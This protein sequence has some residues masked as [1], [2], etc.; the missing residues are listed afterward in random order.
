MKGKFAHIISVISAL[1]LILFSSS[2]ADTSQMVYWTDAS[3]YIIQRA[4]KDGSNVTDILG[5]QGR[6][7][8]LAID[9]GA[10][11]MYWSDMDNKAIRRANLDGTQVETVINTGLMYPRSVALDVMQ[12]KLYWTDIGTR[13]IQCANF[14]GS[15][16]TDLVK[17]TDTAL[18]IKLDLVHNQMYWS[19]EYTS[20][21]RRAN[22]DGTQITDIIV[23][24]W[25]VVSLD[26]DVARNKMY[27][28]T[29]NAGNYKYISSANLDGSDN[30]KIIPSG[31]EAPAPLALD[32]SA[33]K[34]YFVD[35]TRT[36][37]RCNLD[38][39]QIST[40][41]PFIPVRNVTSIAFGPVP[42]PATILLFA[43][44]GLVLRKENN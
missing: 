15:G 6:P 39:S 35:A 34:L 18:S 23:N 14:D 10:G 12:Q 20:K 9:A 37:Y 17:N 30:K 27:F 31:L 19:E 26:L 4:N 21:I 11:K 22:L 28:V 41:L 43:L 38:G 2:F 3:N 33:D 25:W 32:I 5:T 16:I 13:K 44:G 7:N 24:P 29:N 42:E 8:G 1:I 40:F 36:I